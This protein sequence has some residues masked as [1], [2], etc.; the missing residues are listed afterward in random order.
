MTQLPV[1]THS[2]RTMNAGMSAWLGVTTVTSLGSN[3]GLLN[4]LYPVT[5]TKQTTEPQKQISTGSKFNSDLTISQAAVILFVTQT[6]G[7]TYKNKKN[8]NS[9]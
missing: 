7:P 1:N 5:V 6:V 8:P 9:R 4:N 3:L 2:F